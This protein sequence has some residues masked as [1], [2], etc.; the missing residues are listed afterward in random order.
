MFGNG[1]TLRTYYEPGLL[2]D[3]SLDGARIISNPYKGITLKGVI[4]KQRY[5]LRLVR[6]LCAESTER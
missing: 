6:A 5:F 1:L 3:N 4:G 2:Y